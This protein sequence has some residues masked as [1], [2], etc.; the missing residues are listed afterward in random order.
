MSPSRAKGSAPDAI[1]EIDLG[2][3][4]SNWRRLR[5]ITGPR[6]ETGAVIKAD[7]YGLGAGQVGP[8][9]AK[10]GWSPKRTLVYASWDGE[11]PGLLGL[12]RQA[13]GRRVDEA[14]EKENAAA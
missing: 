14:R 4:S 5:Q 2:A 10:A 7:A 1:L 9:L 8:A 6:V 11:E 12:Y 3:I 13:A